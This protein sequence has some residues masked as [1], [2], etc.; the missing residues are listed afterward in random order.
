MVLAASGGGDVDQHRVRLREIATPIEW[1]YMYYVWCMQYK[2][3]LLSTLLYAGAVPRVPA[4]PLLG[5]PDI[6][7]GELRLLRNKI[8]RYKR[9]NDTTYR[10]I[11]SGAVPAQGE[12]DALLLLGMLLHPHPHPSTGAW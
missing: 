11:D 5:T 4:L 12:A 9:K 3:I 1:W 7:R 8:V 2:V 10:Y 6:S